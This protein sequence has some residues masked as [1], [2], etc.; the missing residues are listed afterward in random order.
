MPHVQRANGL[1]EV[2]GVLAVYNSPWSRPSEFLRRAV[3][4]VKTQVFDL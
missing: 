1:V 3:S 2:G 4:R